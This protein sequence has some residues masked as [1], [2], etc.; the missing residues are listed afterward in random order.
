MCY[1]MEKINYKDNK[2]GTK[3]NESPKDN[4]DNCVYFPLPL[5]D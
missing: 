1:N 5:E 2:A 3:S 4:E